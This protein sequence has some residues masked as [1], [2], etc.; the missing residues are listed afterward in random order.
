MAD[1]VATIDQLSK[2]RSR[3]PSKP[4]GTDKVSTPAGAQSTPIAE[5]TPQ[6]PPGSCDDIEINPTAANLWDQ[7]FK[8][9][10]YVRLAGNREFFHKRVLKLLSREAA[11]RIT[12]GL[13]RDIMNRKADF[14]RSKET[15]TAKLRLSLQEQFTKIVIKQVVIELTQCKNEVIARLE[16]LANLDDQVIKKQA[17]LQEE[18]SEKNK[19]VTEAENR[20]NDQ[21]RFVSEHLAD[22]RE[23]EP[24]IGS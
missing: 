8:S 18:T 17:V 22:I 19:K 2:K 11:L 14:I 15:D 23:E 6:R 12:E 7:L 20:V 1:C 5:D 13:K 10:D 24:E 21:V 3:N 4:T 16:Y 9:T